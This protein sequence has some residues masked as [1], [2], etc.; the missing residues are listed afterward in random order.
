MLSHC[1]KARKKKIVY[2]LF[3]HSGR[4]KLEARSNTNS[5]RSWQMLIAQKENPVYVVTQSRCFVF[6]VVSSER[7]IVNF[8]IKDKSKKLRWLYIL[9]LV[10]LFYSK[11]SLF[12]VK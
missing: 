9:K 7:A 3:E 6:T 11:D 4:R 5:D 12:K 2:N 8:L 1:K 10:D